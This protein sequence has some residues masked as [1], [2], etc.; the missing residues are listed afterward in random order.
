MQIN[1]S[2]SAANSFK[3]N[4]EKKP[5]IK[6]AYDIEGCGCAVDG[7]VQLWEVSEMTSDDRIAYDEAATIIYDRRQEVFFEDIIRLDYNEAQYAYAI[8]SDNQIYHP[9]LRI[10]DKTGGMSCQRN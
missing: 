8:K 7:V 9:A 5:I 6:V 4:Y 2:P 10:I 1:V 3:T